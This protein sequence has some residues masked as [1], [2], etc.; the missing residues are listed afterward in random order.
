MN[1]NTI[2]KPRQIA[3]DG[4]A[5][6][7]KTTVGKKTAAKLDYLFF[8]TGLSYRV[9]TYAVLQQVGHVNDVSEIIR[10]VQNA[11]ITLAKTSGGDTA[12]LLEKKD[13]G[14]HLHLPEIDRNVSVVAAIPE[15]RRLLT[16]QQRK[17]GLKG[18]VVLVGRDIGT[19][20]LPDADLKIFLT[21]SA[22]KRAERRFLENQSLG[23]TSDYAEILNE[24]K[25]R[26]QIDSSRDIAPLKPATDAIAIDTD[27]LTVDQVVAKILSLSGY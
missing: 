6:S 25:R 3:V 2:K 27:H 22:E 26:D 10:I 11:Q 9:A 21:A 19:V 5:A 4:P 17:I 8:D 24:I 16:A 1:K 20:V 12:V 15:V 23:I 13:I 18:K 14:C 7:G